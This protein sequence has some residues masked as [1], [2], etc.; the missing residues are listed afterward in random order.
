MRDVV[1]FASPLGPLGA[2]VDRLYMR[3]HMERFLAGLNAQLK[4]TAEQRA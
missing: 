3:R 4:L 1:D 2:L